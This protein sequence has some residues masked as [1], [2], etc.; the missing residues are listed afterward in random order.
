MKVSFG[1][2]KPHVRTERSA[3]GKHAEIR[4]ENRIFRH[5]FK[6]S[7]YARHGVVKPPRRTDNNVGKCARNRT[8]S[9][10]TFVVERIKYDFWQSPKF[11]VHL[12]RSRAS[13]SVS[14]LALK[15]SNPLS[16]PI[17]LNAAVLTFRKVP[18]CS[19]KT[20]PFSKHFQSA[21]RYFA[22]R[23]IIESVVC[24]FAAFGNE[25]IQSLFKLHLIDAFRETSV[26][27][28]RR[29]HLHPVYIAVA[30]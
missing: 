19:C 14:T 16:F 8:N 13:A 21:I 9:P 5:G 3:V 11:C 10:Q 28:E 26:G 22:C 20:T 24:D 18:K 6:L 17:L 2:I 1:K 15:T 12:S 30:R 29:A 4:A 23:K 25:I 27:T 7:F